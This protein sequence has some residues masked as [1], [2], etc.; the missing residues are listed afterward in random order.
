MTF[1]DV[2]HACSLIVMD[3]ALPEHLTTAN[4][5]YGS[6]LKRVVRETSPSEFALLD[7]HLVFRI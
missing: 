3:M 4:V 1:G 2:D 7:P 5:A 6:C